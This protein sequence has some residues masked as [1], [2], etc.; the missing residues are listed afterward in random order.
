MEADDHLKQLYKVLLQIRTLD[1]AINAMDVRRRRAKNNH[2][3]SFFRV[4]QYRIMILNSV[5]DV[6][7]AT[8]RKIMA[9][10][11]DFVRGQ[12][13][14]TLRLPSDDVIVVSHSQ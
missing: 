11:E 8:G 12:N 2:Q 6:Y 7:R 9:D 10:L 14:T 4:F 1:R 5:A 3:L 13:S